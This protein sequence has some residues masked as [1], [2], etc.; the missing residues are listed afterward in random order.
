[1]KR[2]NSGDQIQSNNKA[3]GAEDEEMNAAENGGD[4]K[5]A[6]DAKNDAD[7]DQEER[8]KTSPTAATNSI[9]DK[10]P[11]LLRFFSYQQKNNQ[12]GSSQKADGA[13]G[14]DD[15]EMGEDAFSKLQEDAAMVPSD[16]P[17]R[18]EQLDKLM[19]DAVTK[20]F[21]KTYR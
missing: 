19:I 6:G 17:D 15:P 13:V 21:Q 16:N 3:E 4:G 18:T 7:E 10:Y 5:E 2:L 11:N 9:E 20:I 1:M 12:T 14:A 8:R